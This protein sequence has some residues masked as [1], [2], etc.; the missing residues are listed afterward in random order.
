MWLRFAAL[1][2][3]DSLTGSPMSMGAN[4][5]STSDESEESSEH[6][7]EPESFS[8]DVDT[9]CFESVSDA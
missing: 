6:V 9:S 7:E 2:H 1:G 5:A 3:I 4:F 8:R